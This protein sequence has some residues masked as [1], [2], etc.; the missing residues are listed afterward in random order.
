MLRL[1]IKYAITHIED[2]ALWVLH[3]DYPK[4]LEEWDSLSHDRLRI[5]YDP[6]KK[7]ST[8]SEVISLGHEFQL[9]TI[10]PAAYTR[11]IE[12]RML[13]GSFRSK[14]LWFLIILFEQKHI[15]NDNRLPDKARERCLIGYARI[16][17]YLKEKSVEACCPPLLLP[18]TKCRT[19]RKCDANKCQTIK[20]LPVWATKESRG[21][22]VF[23]KKYAVVTEILCSKCRAE[24][25]K[26]TDEVRSDFWSV[27]PSFF[28]L[29]DW[30]D[31]RDEI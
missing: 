22:G 21:F 3:H 27:L 6:Q 2:K 24:V 13:V 4:T 7:S 14:T 16:L 8:T 31:L 10:L 18:S 29:P 12:Q 26:L 1:G 28:E 20:D 15:G 9:L 11:Y 17:A 19:R 5:R 23:K 30:T 25:K